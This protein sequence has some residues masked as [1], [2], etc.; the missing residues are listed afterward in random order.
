[1]GT[2]T[3]SVASSAHTRIKTLH[4]AYQVLVGK[5]VD[6]YLAVVNSYQLGGTTASHDRMRTVPIGNVW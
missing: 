3:V 4:S 5:V 6:V 1:M 2:G